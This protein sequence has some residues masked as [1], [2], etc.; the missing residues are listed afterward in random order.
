MN[1]GVIQD[2]SVGVVFV[3]QLDIERV[4]ALIGVGVAV[5]VYVGDNFANSILEHQFVRA[6]RED[7]IGAVVGNV[8]NGVGEPNGI[9]FGI[10]GDNVVDDLIFLVFSGVEESV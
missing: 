1:R 6:D 10:I 9:L 5:C 3:G 8:G 2:V 7:N 4:G